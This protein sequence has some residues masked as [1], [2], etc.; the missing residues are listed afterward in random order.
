MIVRSKFFLLWNE[1]FHMTYCGKK[2]LVVT[3]KKH[4]VKSIYKSTMYLNEWQGSHR[5]KPRWRQFP[6]F[7]FCRQERTTR[8]EKINDD[9]EIMIA[10]TWFSFYSL[11]S[12]NT[13][14]G[15]RKRTKISREKMV[16]H[17]TQ[18]PTIESHNFP[19]ISHINY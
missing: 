2:F 18:S 8:E 15:Q 1:Y 17:V 11:F 10:T 6:I 19:S 4:A 7:W 3:G 16:E 14:M 13:I 5:E 9:R 12:Y